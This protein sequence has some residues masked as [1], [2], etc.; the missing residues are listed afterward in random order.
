MRYDFCDFLKGLGK[1][2]VEQVTYTLAYAHIGFDFGK[3]TEVK[4]R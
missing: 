4:D 3:S 1:L 2:C